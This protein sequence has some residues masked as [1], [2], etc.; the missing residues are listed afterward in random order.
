M[1]I[2]RLFDLWKRAFAKGA[3]YGGCCLLLVGIGLAAY[4]RIFIAQSIATT[5]KVIRLEPQADPENHS[6]NYSPVFSFVSGDGKSYTVHGSVASNPPEFEE[7]Q[8]VNVRYIPSNPM[9]ASIDSGI[10]MWF[11]PLM[12]CIVGVVFALIGYFLLR[13]LRKRRNSL[14]QGVSIS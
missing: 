1:K 2:S 9:R 11:A 12:F 4:T 3:L 8:N 6:V 13:D 5:G 7:G 10:Q 14:L